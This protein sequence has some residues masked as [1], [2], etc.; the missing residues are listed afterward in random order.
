MAVQELNLSYQNMDILYR[1]GFWNYGNL[2]LVPLQQ[3]S[4]GYPKYHPKGGYLSLV[5]LVG[6]RAEGVRI[7]PGFNKLFALGM[8]ATAL[9][10]NL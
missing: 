3:P 5:V 2:I 10:R 8:R 4:L 6:F 7:G 9:A 1:L